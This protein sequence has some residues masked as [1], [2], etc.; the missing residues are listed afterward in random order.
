[1]PKKQVISR[2]KCPSSATL[3][4]VCRPILPAGG[5]WVSW[6]QLRSCGRGSLG[7]P[8][9]WVCVGEA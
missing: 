9:S 8:S 1:M 3:E 6:E 7:S 2:A 5:G 4:A